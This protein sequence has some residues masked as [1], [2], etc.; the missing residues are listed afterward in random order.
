MLGRTGALSQTTRR[1]YSKSMSNPESEFAQGTDA[2][3][4]HVLAEKAYQEA[5]ETT[6][7]SAVYRRLRELQR[8]R[9]EPEDGGARLLAEYS[10]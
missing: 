6:G 2:S 8:W 4:K 7:L 3:Y 1:M 10:H 9:K 5:A